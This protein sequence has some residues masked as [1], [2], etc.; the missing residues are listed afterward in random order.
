M[1]Y[2]FKVNTKLEETFRY[3]IYLMIFNEFLNVGEFIYV[4]YTDQWLQQK[5]YINMYE[6]NPIEMFC[7]FVCVFSTSQNILPI[8]FYCIS[9]WKKHIFKNTISTI[10]LSTH[11]TMINF[12]E[13][14]LC[15]I[16]R[17]LP[18]N[19]GRAFDYSLRQFVTRNFNNGIHY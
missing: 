9:I 10:K 3:P 4:A 18:T 15:S 6:L 16:V 7:I 8:H 1:R 19:F 11:L 14:E 12:I 5:P 13:Q 2:A 17:T